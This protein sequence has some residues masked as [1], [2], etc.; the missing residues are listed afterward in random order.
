MSS[1]SLAWIKQILTSNCNSQRIASDSAGNVYITGRNYG[2]VSGG[3]RLDANGDILIFKM[4]TNGNLVWIKQ[5]AVMNTNAEQSEPYIVVDSSGNSYVTYLV[6]GAVSGGQNSNAANFDIVVFKMDTN[7]NMIWIK[8]P[9]SLNTS[10][11]E[12]R[13]QIALDSSNNIYIT[14]SS[15][16]TVSSG[17]APVGGFPDIVVCKMD[18][19]GNIIWIKQQRVMSTSV[20]DLV[21]SISVDSSGNVHVAYVTG[22]GT[23]S[24]GIN[25]GVS[26]DMVVFKMDTNGN[27]VW[28]KQPL[29]L[30]TSGSD[31]SQFKYIGVD[32]SGN[33]YITYETSGVVSGGTLM[34]GTD[35]VISKLDSNGNLVWIK[36]TALM[37]SIFNESKSSI[38]VDS[39]GNSYLAYL[40]SDGAVSGGTFVGGS[41]DV[42]VCRMD[43]NGNIVWIQ[44]NQAFNVGEYFGYVQA[45]VSITVDS[46]KNIYVSYDTR[47]ATS[48]NSTD[49]N[50]NTAV[51]KL[52]PPPPSTATQAVAEGNIGGFISA[53]TT[54][55]DTQKTTLAV[56]MRT[57]I[58]NATFAD[59]AA[60]AASQLS[61]INSMISKVG[62]SYTVPLASFA[63]FTATLAS[64]TSGLSSKPI[65][66]YFPTFSGTSTT[67][68]VSS[69][70]ATNYVH[71]EV[72]VGYSLTL[73]NGAATKTLT[74]NGTSYTDGTNTYTTNTSIVLGDKTYTIVGIGSVVIDAQTNNGGSV[75]CMQEGTQILTPGG[76]V[77]IESLKEGDQV[78]T[79]TK[80]VTSIVK[81]HKIVVVSATDKNAPYVIEKNAFGTNCPPNRLEVSPRHAIQLE[82]GLWE[83]P[84]EAAKENK[85]VYQNKD[86][87]GKQVIYYHF[88]LPN[89]VTDTIVVNGQIT[90]SLNDEK[91]VE[92]YTWNKQRGGY[93]RSIKPIEKKQSTS[94]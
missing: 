4:N 30:N 9:T 86:M 41:H 51:F 61:Y 16:G 68:D 52:V 56:D 15:A 69:A 22:G 78:I 40:K 44:Q 25:N 77:P 1:P 28:I 38:Y 94:A 92:S 90:E 76:Y 37:N 20:N 29:V 65:T 62:A 63:S 34:G 54:T 80:E 23:V 13:P 57:A 18:T 47:A 87:I 70:S 26:N 48:G 72:P 11:N 14:Y 55:T 33:I 81:M 5:Q 89:Y 53:Q 8:Q 75:E 43:T 50:I 45:T 36:Q 88:S 58:K 83:I 79:G 67:L 19:N 35:I 27:L 85:S 46:S 17:T 7:G 59:N 3:T 6:K 2:T 71:V 10:E 24:G 31:Y 66:S 73:Q 64:V 21:P 42:V 60:K 74:N 39:S 12:G 91:V 82:P 49:G 93:I 84:R 32:N